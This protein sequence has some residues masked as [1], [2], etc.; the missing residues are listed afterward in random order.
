MNLF[1]DVPVA[2]RRAEIEQLKSEMG[3]CPTAGPMIAENWLRAPS[4][5]FSLYGSALG[6]RQGRA[7][8]T[9]G[10]S[11]SPRSAEQQAV[12]SIGVHAKVRPHANPNRHLGCGPAPDKAKTRASSGAKPASKRAAGAVAQAATKMVKKGRKAGRAGKRIVAAGAKVAIEK[13]ESAVHSAADATASALNSVV[14]R[15]QK[16]AEK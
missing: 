11:W 2:E 14:D 10:Q 9:E 8:Y 1:I 16:I 7:N 12:A 3:E 4:G 15:V 6:L 5:S 13:I